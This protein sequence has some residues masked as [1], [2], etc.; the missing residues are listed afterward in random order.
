MMY[1]CETWSTAEKNRGMLNNWERRI[2]KIYGPITDPGISGSRTNYKLRQLY[3]SGDL[4]A[5]IKKET[6]SKAF[7]ACD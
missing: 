2:F 3:K 7:G 6:A 4:V 5:D 1:G